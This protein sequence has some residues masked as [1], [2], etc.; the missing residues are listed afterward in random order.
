VPGAFEPPRIV[1]SATI[2]TTARIGSA[3]AR[4]P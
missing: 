3:Y 4:Q 1:A 2:V